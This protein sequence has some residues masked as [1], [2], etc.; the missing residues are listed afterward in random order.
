MPRKERETDSHLLASNGVWGTHMLN[1]YAFHMRCRLLCYQKPRSIRQATHIF[2]CCPP[3]W[4]RS[5]FHHLK[6]VAGH[7]RVHPN[8]TD[9]PNWNSGTNVFAS[10]HIIITK[11][12]TYSATWCGGGRTMLWG[13]LAAAQ[14][15][16]RVYAQCTCIGHEQCT[17]HS[18][19]YQRSLL[20]TQRTR[21]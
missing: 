12:L 11:G 13:F 20:A 7:Y 4:H 16:I 21:W 3:L 10:T 15:M 17:H 9:F 19:E 14:A 8:V 6:P 2:G 1:L 5:G 18:F